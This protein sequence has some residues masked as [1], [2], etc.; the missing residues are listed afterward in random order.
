MQGREFVFDVEN[1]EFRDANDLENT[2]DIHSG[3]GRTAHSAQYVKQR[4][5][6]H[7]RSPDNSNRFSGCQLKARV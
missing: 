1:R 6:S 4:K 7:R 2:V 3:E 5:H